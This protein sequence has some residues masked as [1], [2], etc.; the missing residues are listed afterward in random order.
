MTDVRDFLSRL[1]ALLDGAEIPY[2]LTGS[3]ASTYHGTPCATQDLDLVIDSDEASLGRLLGSLATDEYYF[4][5]EAAR[6][7]VRRRGLFNIIAK[8][9]WAA[10]GQSERQ[11]RDVVGILDTVGG[12]DTRYIETWVARLD[13][14]DW[15]DRARGS[16]LSS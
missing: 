14:G 10:R 1:V 2:M 9:E 15:W 4:S 5:D 3:F 12:L 7:A 13:L 11:L 8:L 6:Q 16:T